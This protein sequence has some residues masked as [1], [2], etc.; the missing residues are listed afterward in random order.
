MNSRFY[1]LLVAI[2]IATTSLF[3]QPE[4][5]WQKSL[6]G[7]LSDAANYVTQTSDG[8]YIV[9]GVSRSTDGD[10][11]SGFGWMDYWIVKLAAD[12]TIEWEN[13]YG[14]TEHDIA[15][16]I[17][18]TSDGGYIVAGRADSEDGQITNHIGSTDFWILKLDDEGAIEWENTYGGWASDYAYSVC[19]TT[20][21]GYIVGGAS[22]SVAGGVVTG[23]HGKYDFWVV[24][25]SEEGDL[26]WQKSLGG[27]KDDFL[28]SIEQTDDGGYIM[29]GK[30]QSN[31]GDVTG[32][33]GGGNFVH[34]YWV[35]KLSSDAEIE[36]Q[37]SLGGTD[38]EVA[39]SVRQGNDGNYIVAGLAR[40]TDGDVSVNIGGWDYWIVK[41]S[42][43]GEIIWEKSYGGLHDD[44]AHSINI[45]ADGG[46][47]AVGSSRSDWV[48]VSENYGGQDY[49]V[50]KLTESGDLDWEKSLGGTSDEIAFSVEQ[51]NDEGFIIAGQ[52]ASVNG[53]V[54][55]NHGSND[56]W[57]VKLGPCAVNTE[58]E[59]SA[60]SIVSKEV[61]LSSSFQ[62]MDC[63]TGAIIPDEENASFTPEIGGEYAV[64]VT[65]GTCV[66]TS[67]CVAFCPL[68]TDVLV[69]DSTLQSLEEGAD[70]SFQWINCVDSSFVEGAINAQ[71]EP[72]VNGD[73]AV[74]VTDDNCTLISDCITMCPEF[75]NNEVLVADGTI[76]SLADTAFTTFQ[77]INCITAAPVEGAV[78]PAFTPELSGDY[79]VVVTKGGCSV[80]SECITF[81]MINNDIILEGNSIQS[82]SENPF[83]QFQW[84]DCAD[85]SPIQGATGQS[86]IPDVS[87]EYAVIISEA[88]CIDTS[89]CINICQINTAL[90]LADNTIISAAAEEAST[91]QWINCIEQTVISNET[92]QAFS[93]AVSGDYAVIITQGSCVDTTDCISYCEIDSGV[94]LIDNEIIAAANAEIST[95]QWINCNDQSLIAGATDQSYI[96]TSSGEYAV[97]VNQANCTVT[98]DCITF[99]AIDTNLVVVDNTIVSESNAEISTYQWFDC[100]DESLVF[101]ETEQSFTPQESG[102]YA[103]I[104]VQGSCL[105]SSECVEIVIVETDNL[106]PETVNVFPNPAKN[107]ITITSGVE[108]ADARLALFD[109]TGEKVY[110]GAFNGIEKSVSLSNVP[111]G[112]Y[113]I[114]LES[115][116]AVLATR[117]VKSR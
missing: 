93:P 78:D 36:W 28:Y 17:K 49:W 6:G 37:K 48:D 75:I 31:N 70:V 87:G 29:A 44:L 95:F 24:K 81:C 35:V 73:Y 59:V 115:L 107:Y 84:I 80:T 30:S 71:F 83:A 66:D 79:A 15:S 104:I 7:S 77:W 88:S 14:G 46:Y 19:E 2:F 8:G 51:T 34:D 76:Q 112:V 61:A 47:I 25:L 57:V 26:E 12:G 106:K 100:S 5:E 38:H 109:L 42:S 91:F 82:A 56:Y 64:I 41:L 10:V 90:T 99:C 58:L 52:S 72:V 105:E 50:I 92:G 39:Y 45:T 117:F 53:L 68:I 32:N 4:I 18:E 74:I 102:E 27:S 108:L 1:L 86:F 63:T 22:N 54:T 97:M 98:S 85:Q 23:N 111:D 101:G 69:E 62:W 16:E 116:N 65:N 67:E 113:V 89:V 20:D 103:V 55:G 33:H 96:P 13:T 21:G 114:K 60:T 40:S 11:A 3:S 9:A 94:T 43:V 110:E